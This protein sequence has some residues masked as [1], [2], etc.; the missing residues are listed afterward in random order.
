ML[1]GNQGFQVSL[2]CGAV[3]EDQR[4]AFEAGVRRYRADVIRGESARR[5]RAGE[6]DPAGAVDSRDDAAR[7][8]LCF[9]LRGRKCGAKNEDGNGA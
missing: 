7:R 6:R 1:R 8:G 3:V 2:L 5:P 9:G 4:H